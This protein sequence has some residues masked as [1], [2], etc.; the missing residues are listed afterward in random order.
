[1]GRLR[2]KFFE[3]ESL[4]VLSYDGYLTE[5]LSN[6]RQEFL[7]QLPGYGQIRNFLIDLSR[8]TGSDETA[9]RI[10]GQGLSVRMAM[11]AAANTGSKLYAMVAP[12][13]SPGYPHARM[14]EMLAVS[15]ENILAEVFETPQEGAE[16]LCLDRPAATY[17]D[18]STPGWTLLMD[19]E[20]GATTPGAG[21]HAR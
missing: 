14:Y 8:L 1:M 20:E 15:F 4:V 13:D 11:A 5:D 7:R 18:L 16:W 10:T 6:R 21:Q 12:Q 17:L 3:A 19:A 2:A 9:R